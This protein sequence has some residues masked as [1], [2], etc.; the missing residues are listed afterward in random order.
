M[1]EQGG[2]LVY[3]YLVDKVPLDPPLQLLHL[4][5][6]PFNQLGRRRLQFLLLVWQ[7]VCK[8]RFGIHAMCH[9]WH[10]ACMPICQCFVH[11]SFFF[12]VLSFSLPFNLLYACR[13]FCMFIYLLF[14]CLPFSF[15]FWSV[16]TS[17]TKLPISLIQ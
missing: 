12:F 4:I 1:E 13:S 6:V 2:E 9:M 5:G 17:I 11:L 16:Y 14:F 3:K 15:F 10:I 8:S 7:Q